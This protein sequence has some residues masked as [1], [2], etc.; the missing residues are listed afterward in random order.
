MTLF[1]YTL[2]FLRS[3]RNISLSALS[4]SLQIG[5]TTLANIESGYISPEDTTA[6]QIADFFGVTV[7]YMK[8]SVEFTLP[9]AREADGSVHSPQRFVRLRPVALPLDDSG[10]GLGQSV[11]E[12]EIILPLPAG[13]RSAYIA[14][15][16]TD[17][18][19]V[20]Y[21][22]MAGD[23]LI[24]RQDPLQIRDGELVLLLTDAGQTVLRRYFREGDTVMLRSDEDDLEPPVR[25]SDCDSSC[26]LVG[27]VMHIWI[28][29]DGAFAHRRAQN[30]PLLPDEILPPPNM[31][32]QTGNRGSLAAYKFD[33]GFGKKP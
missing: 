28:D 30:P 16:V 9:G 13:D 11:S 23:T 15:K 25:L 27:S 8:G 3:R 17:N 31:E 7:A 2:R 14:V 32:A 29:T 12:Q 5:E 33:Y 6:K 21:R 22:A 10:N 26:R 4:H 24:V 20:R 1:G 19:M 18:T